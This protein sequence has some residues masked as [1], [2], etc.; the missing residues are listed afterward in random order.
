MD[1]TLIIA[2][3]IF[4]VLIGGV[5]AVYKSDSY[6]SQMGGKHSNKSL[7]SGKLIFLTFLFLVISLAITILHSK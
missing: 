6:V 2:S 5:T 3:L 1:F 7:K 4:L